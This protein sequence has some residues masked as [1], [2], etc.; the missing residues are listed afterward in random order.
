MEENNVDQIQQPAQ[1]EIQ[2]TP[3]SQPAI[4]PI[5]K[6]LSGYKSKGLAAFIVV[7]ILVVLAAIALYA[8]K[9]KLLSNVTT[10]TVNENTTEKPAA[11]DNTGSN[12]T[13]GVKPGDTSPSS[14]DSQIKAIE[15][16]NMNDIDS[17]FGSNDLNDLNS[18]Q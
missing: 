18:I 15:N 14:L 2:P 7:A 13:N 9:N 17:S 12:N 5:E 4:K 8:Y 11:S 3:E 16:I 10:P 1:S 6:E